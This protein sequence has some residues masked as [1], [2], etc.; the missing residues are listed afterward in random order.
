[1][2]VNLYTY[3]YGRSFYRNEYSSIKKNY[4]KQQHIS[5]TYNK[6]YDKIDGIVIVRGNRTNQKL[7][8]YSIQKDLSALMT[9]YS[10]KDA[11]LN[12]GLIYYFM[13]CRTNGQ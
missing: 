13:K 1:M 3:L 10:S 4:K 11:G 12:S 8:Y 7:T 6:V 5:V 2:I 9:T